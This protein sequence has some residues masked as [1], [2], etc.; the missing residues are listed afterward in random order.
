MLGT[1]YTYFP[2]SRVW[3][4][5]AKL[6][7]PQAQKSW[8]PVMTLILFLPFQLCTFQPSFFPF[9]HISPFLRLLLLVHIG[10]CYL[11]DPSNLIHH[12]DDACRNSLLFLL[13]TFSRSEKLF[14]VQ[15]SPSMYTCV[16]LLSTSQVLILYTG[17]A[18]S[19]A[20]DAPCGPQ[21]MHSVDVRSWVRLDIRHRW[22]ESVNLLNTVS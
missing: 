2:S 15:I 9:Y 1:F 5:L 22:L 12:G 13:H 6:A 16:V 20:L 10:V 8:M 17:S 11:L 18:A 7:S 19:R 3:L 14:N 21:K 4:V